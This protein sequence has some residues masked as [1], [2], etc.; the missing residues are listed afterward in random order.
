ML[1]GERPLG[2]SS[3]DITAQIPQCNFYWLYAW[4]VNDYRLPILNSTQTNW[5]KGRTVLEQESNDW[6]IPTFICVSICVWRRGWWFLLGW[7]TQSVHQW[8]I[9]SVCEWPFDH[10]SLFCW[11]LKTDRWREK[12][13]RLFKDFNRWLAFYLISNSNY[14]TLVF[15]VITGPLLCDMRSSLK[16][17]VCEMGDGELLSTSIGWSEVYENDKA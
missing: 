13:Y 1:P 16:V 4:T 9:K 17:G 3:E 8:S 7:S 5:K 11:I 12:W 14:C 2:S 10:I 6:R 15:L